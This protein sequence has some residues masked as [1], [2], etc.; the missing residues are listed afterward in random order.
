MQ[1]KISHTFLLSFKKF[2]VWLDFLIQN[3][4]S[5]D[6]HF[7]L[8]IYLLFFALKKVT[9]TKQVKILPSIFLDKILIWDKTSPIFRIEITLLYELCLL[10][11]NHILITYKTLTLVLSIHRDSVAVD[12]GNTQNCNLTR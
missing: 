5:I 8:N 7:Y 10:L 11:F 2:R 4:T 9:K 12:P 3:K 1:R 6:T